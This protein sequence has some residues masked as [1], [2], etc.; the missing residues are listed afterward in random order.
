MTI[1]NLQPA[2]ELWDNGFNIIPIK[3]NPITPTQRTL[4]KI[5]ETTKTPFRKVAT[6]SN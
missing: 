4:L 5:L 2:L 6:V 1:N 3:S